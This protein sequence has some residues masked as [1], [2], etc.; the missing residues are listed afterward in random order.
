MNISSSL[1]AD[2]DVL[3]IS[4]HGVFDFKAHAEFRATYEALPRRPRSFIVD[5]TETEYLDSSALGMLLLLRKHASSGSEGVV[6]RNARPSVAKIL[7]IANF[8][9]LFEVA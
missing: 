8:Q 3:T 9:E 6:L 2:G 7:K 5:L 1:S 4:V